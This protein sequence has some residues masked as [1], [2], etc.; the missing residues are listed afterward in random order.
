MN[1]WLAVAAVAAFH[2]AT[3]ALTG[4]PALHEMLSRPDA[5]YAFDTKATLPT[6]ETIERPLSEI[7][8]A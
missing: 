7:L 4:E 6:V 5:R 3:G 2:A 8:A 1:L